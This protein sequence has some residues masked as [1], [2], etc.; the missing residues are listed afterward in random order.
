[1][2]T[3]FHLASVLVCSF[4]LNAQITTVL[5]RPSNR[6]PEIVIR[7]SSM[8]NLTAF[9]VSMAPVAQEGASDSAPFIVYIDTAVDTDR[10]AVP[11]RPRTAMPLPPNQEYAV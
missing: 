5:N 11:Y 4:S 7:N 1:M 2:K 9:A 10:L 8:A 3:V 6:S